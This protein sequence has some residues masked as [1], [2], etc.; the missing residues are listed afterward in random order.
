M[1]ETEFKFANGNTKLTRTQL[2]KVYNKWISDN[3]K[4]WQKIKSNFD[5]PFPELQRRLTPQYGNP[6]W[7]EDLNIKGRNSLIGSMPTDDNPGQAFQ[8]ENKGKDKVGFISQERRSV[9]RGVPSREGR[10]WHSSP[11]AEIDARA[12]HSEVKAYNAGNNPLGRKLTPKDDLFR[13]IEHK[14]RIADPFWDTQFEFGPGDPENLTWTSKAQWKA[15]DS[16]EMSGKNKLIYDVDDITGDI[17]G[18]ERNKFDPWKHTSQQG[19]IVWDSKYQRFITPIIENGSNGSNGS[20]GVNGVN[21]GNGIKNGLLE[22]TKV[23][24]KALDKPIIK[25]GSRY[26]LGGGSVFLTT[27]LADTQVKAAQHNPTLRNKILAGGR[28]AEASLDWLGLAALGSGIGAPAA[29]P[30]ELM[31]MGVGGVTDLGEYIT[32]D[33]YKDRGV[34]RGR[35]GAK[36]AMNANK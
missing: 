21:G 35:S 27:L 22:K 6:W 18:I 9:T 15:K 3:S 13:R 23:I 17:R 8:I 10:I 19:D 16:L 14:I 2:S 1:S 33:A 32:S 5:D 24:G 31:S 26:A 29:V 12:F 25:K 34:I 11:D 4:E 20:N 36:A 28:T 30:F 7:R